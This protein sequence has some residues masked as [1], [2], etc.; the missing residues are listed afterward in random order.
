MGASPSTEVSE[1][2]YRS[3]IT[4]NAGLLRELISNLRIGTGFQEDDP[5]ICLPNLIYECGHLLGGWCCTAAYAGEDRSDD[6]KMIP[7]GE[8]TKTLVVGD[9]LSLIYRNNVDCL[10][11]PAIQL[12][13]L[14]LV[15]GCIFIEGAFA[16]LGPT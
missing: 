3:L 2:V 4:L 8:I 5:G 11:D 15:I 6:L 7:V 14:S 9:D 13:Q 12:F 1:W 16:G 10:L